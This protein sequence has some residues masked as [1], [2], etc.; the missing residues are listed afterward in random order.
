MDVTLRYYLKLT[1]DEAIATYRKFID[2]VK[3]VE[4][5][6][7]NLWHND[8]VSDFREWKG[9]KKVFELSLNHMSVEK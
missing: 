5:T 7:I 6:W 2:T 3:A 8:S 1:P 9:W 4:G